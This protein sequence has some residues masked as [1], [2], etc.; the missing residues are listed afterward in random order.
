MITKYFPPVSYGGTEKYVEVISQKLAEKGLTVTILGP[1]TD[2]NIT[3]EQNGPIQICRTP[4]NHIK[5]IDFSVPMKNCLKSLSY[6]VAHFNTFSTLC[7][8]LRPALSSPYVITTHG[9]FWKKPAITNPIN[10]FFK[11]KILK[12]N[13][14]KSNKIFCV[15]KKDYENVTNMFGYTPSKLYYTPNGVDLKKFSNHKKDKTKTK[16][17]L[18][19]KILITQVGRFAPQKG[20]HLLLDALK[21]M[22]K[23]TLEKS[24]T[25]LA[26]YPFDNQYFLMLEQTI[27][28]NNLEK[29]VKLWPKIND[30][31]LLDLYTM[32]DIFVLPSLIEGLPLTLLEAWA[33]KCAV[34]VTNV[35]GLPYVVHDQ[36]DG[37]IVPPNNFVVLS[38]KIAELVNNDEKRSL[39]SEKGFERAKNE[40]DLDNNINFLVKQYKEL[41]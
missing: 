12:E 41:L 28:R 39:F 29:D 40:F 15:S 23:K 11:V 38:Q 5:F 36:I 10:Y 25:I 14:Q 7:S 18:E 9:F 26:G 13:F 2:K 33:S 4:L 30:N 1:S 22:P 34:I 27:K 16:Y 3:Y 8:F 19:N 24:T 6:D 32:T 35:G 31:L 21:V 20:Q 17:G 37:C